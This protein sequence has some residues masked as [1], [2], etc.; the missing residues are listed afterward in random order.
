MWTKEL[1]KIKCID[2][3]KSDNRKAYNCMCL[4]ICM[5]MCVNVL[6]VDNKKLHSVIWNEIEIRNLH[7]ITPTT[8]GN[9]VERVDNE[10]ITMFIC[11]DG[12]KIDNKKKN[13]KQFKK[14]KN[15]KK[16]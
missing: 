7:S 2:A 14:S 11:V 8:Q 9:G 13:K 4:Y 12:A 15:W 5:Y 6:G 16:N 3:P 1:V 10:K